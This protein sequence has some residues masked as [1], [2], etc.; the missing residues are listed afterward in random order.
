[1]L[2]EMRRKDRLLP[3]AE[4]EAILKKV[5]FGVLATMGAEGYPYAVPL[6]FAYED[7]KIYLHCAANAGMKEAA[8]AADPH[9]CFTVIGDTH[10][11]PEKFGT[12]Y[13]SVVVLGRA[14]KLTGAEKQKAMEAMVRK[15]SA[16][17]WE[18]GLKYIQ[19]T[20]EKADAY[21]IEIDQMTGKAKRG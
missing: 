20:Y 3:Q 2:N 4:A 1:M 14:A 7:G 15:Y 9:V 16:A 13:E 21:A 8:M 17:Y 6:S 18:G 12:L 19:G 5:S 11:M 10:V